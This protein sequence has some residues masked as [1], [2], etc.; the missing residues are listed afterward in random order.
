MKTLVVDDHVLIREALHGIL[1]ELSEAVTIIEAGDA[2]EA[3]QQ[4]EDHPDL[5][6]VL[7]DLYLPDRDGFD[8]LASLR[9]SSPAT[10]VAVLSV[11]SDRA[12]IT[13]ALELGVLG[14]IP[15]SAPREVMV[16]ALRLILSGG[17]YVPPE[18]F[19]RPRASPAPMAPAKRLAGAAELGLTARQMD[20]LALMMEG[21]SNKA[22]CREL[23]LAEPTVK[24]HVTAILKALKVTNRTEAVLAAAARGFGR[25]EG[26]R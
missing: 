10:P 20:V 21:K 24:N 17:T 4:I 16:G 2:G 1:R 26:A 6:L 22:I 7:L 8:L 14:F 25:R 11:S 12:D 13:R 3:W 15:K 19:G 23:D 9:E 5:D 18:I